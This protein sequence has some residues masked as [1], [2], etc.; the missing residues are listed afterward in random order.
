MN[1]C[2]ICECINNDWMCGWMIMVHI[3]LNKL[4]GTS[5]GIWAKIENSRKS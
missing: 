1:K 4:G 3:K 5:V 2:Q